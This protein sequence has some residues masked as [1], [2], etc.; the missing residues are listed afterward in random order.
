[1]NN[2]KVCKQTVNPLKA[3]NTQLHTENGKQMHMETILAALHTK[4]EHRLWNHWNSFTVYSVKLVKPT[5][6]SL[7]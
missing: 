4:Q 5:V 1:M 3:L 7:K 2:E 6:S